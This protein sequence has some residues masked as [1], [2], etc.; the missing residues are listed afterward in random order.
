MPYNPLDFYK[1]L[2]IALAGGFAL[3]CL[4]IPLGLWGLWKLLAYF[5]FNN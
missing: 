5:V 4:L 3:A 1:K 2:I